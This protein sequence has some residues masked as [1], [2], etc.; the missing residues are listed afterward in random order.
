MNTTLLL[1]ASVF[2]AA[3]PVTKQAPPPAGS[4]G[5]SSD[6]KCQLLSSFCLD[7]QDRFLLCDQMKKRLRVVTA[8]DKLVK[9]YDLDFGPQVVACRA[10]GSILVAGSGKIAVLD[11]QGTKQLGADLPVGAAATTAVGAGAKDIFVCCMSKTGFA[12][13]R[14]DDKLQN[15]TTIISGLRGCC[16]QMDF[17]VRDDKV[18]VA[19]NTQFKIETYDRDRKTHV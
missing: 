6:T 12:V 3:A 13:S 10:D 5:V 8:D 9:D 4:I 2:L 19:H 14:Y 15:P 1:V 17:K 18:F 16:G 7:S 11:A